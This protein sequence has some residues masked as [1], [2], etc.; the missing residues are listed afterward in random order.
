MDFTN[1]AK[2]VSA[3]Q[4]EEVWLEL[5]FYRDRKHRDDV[6]AKMKNDES[7]DPLF[8]TVYGYCNL[9]IQHH[10]GRVQSHQSLGINRPKEDISTLRE[11]NARPSITPSRF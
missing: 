6:M 2:T 11:I 7:A 8:R 5:N 3:N 1:I 9:W 10:Y 4:D